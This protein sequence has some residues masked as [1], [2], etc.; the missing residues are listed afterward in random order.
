[1]KARS[2]LPFLAI[3]LLQP[4]LAA[5]SLRDQAKNLFEPIPHSP[6]PLPGEVSTPEKLALGKMLFFDPRLSESQDLSCSRCHNISMG[7]VGPQSSATGHLGELGG[8]TVRTVLNA[9]FNK[10][11]YWDGRTADLK[12]Q[13]SAS[14][15]ANPKALLKTRGGPIIVNPAEMALT[16]QHAVERFQAIPGYADVFRKAFPDE[17]DPISYDNIA[18]AIALFEATLI[19]PD[20]SFDRWLLG[21]DSA[22]SPEQLQGLKLF[23]EKGCANCHKGVNF[24]GGGYARFGV[25]TAPGPEFLPPDDWGRAAA[26]KKFEDR[27]VFKIPGLRNIELTAP[28][29]HA[30]G[31]KDLRT[32]VAVMSEAQ[33]GQKLSAEEIDKLVAFLKSLTGRQPEV[34]LPI[35]PPSAPAPTPRGD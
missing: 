14:V 35:L 12:E 17:A 30:G 29:F 11:Q 32:A 2:I 15:M 26:T 1:M 34:V 9:V 10:S 28:Y 24:G 25:A 16:R 19:T 7:G 33:L 21:D 5:E 4:A 18:K 23:I 8:R 6:P 20:C 31:A 22:L 13:V 3:L 27:Y